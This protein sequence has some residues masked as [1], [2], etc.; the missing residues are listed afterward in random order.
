M[1][2]G[3][4]SQINEALNSLQV[5]DDRFT[6]EMVREK[7]RILFLEESIAN[8][9]KEIRKEHQMC[10]KEALEVLNLHRPRNATKA[11]GYMPSLQGEISQRKQ[12]FNM[13]KQLNAARIRLSV[14]ESENKQIKEQINQLRRR[15]QT[16]D[17]N[18]R[19]FEEEVTKIQK[20]VTQQLQLAAQVKEAHQKTLNRGDMLLQKNRDH[21]AKHQVKYEQLASYIDDQVKDFKKSITEA[22]KHAKSFTDDDNVRGELTLEQEAQINIELNELAEY[23]ETARQQEIETQQKIDEQTAGLQRLREAAKKA[24]MASGENFAQAMKYDDINEVK[25]LYLRNQE[26]TFSIFKYIQEQ[27]EER[28]KFVEQ[29]LIIEDDAVKL[30]RHFA[31]EEEERKKKNE[32]K[33]KQ[34]LVL[35]EQTKEFTDTSTQQ[36]ISIEQLAKKVQSL[37]YKIQCDQLGGREGNKKGGNKQNQGQ[38]RDNQVVMVEGVGVG[39]GAVNESNILKFLELIEQR[40]VEIVA[41]FTKKMDRQEAKNLTPVLTEKPKGLGKNQSLLETLSG[42]DLIPD[43]FIEEEEDEELPVSTVDIKRST[44]EKLMKQSF[45]QS[46]TE[47]QQGSVAPDVVNRLPPSK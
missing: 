3:G 26:E 27:I 14:T 25:A 23:L 15:R 42:P 9:H 19:H 4:Q 18:R 13:E 22:E 45:Y 5:K 28:D 16:C 10:G 24:A 34:M 40:A 37:F 11:D 1:S 43:E 31:I 39:G 41:D 17:L 44:A 35:V 7:K 21:A 2:I 38:Q 29:S 46:A 12:V 6:I 33:N 30:R 47:S 8:V 20:S 36:Q 32:E